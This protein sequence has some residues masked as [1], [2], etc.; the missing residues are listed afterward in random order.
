[1]VSAIA[2]ATQVVEKHFHIEAAGQLR[3]MYNGKANHLY[4]AISAILFHQCMSV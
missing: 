3:D 1:M 4:P 2:S